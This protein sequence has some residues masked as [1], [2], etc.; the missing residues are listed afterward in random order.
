MLVFRCP[1]VIFINDINTLLPY[2][3]LTWLCPSTPS[4]PK[5]LASASVLFIGSFVI[6]ITM[7][8]P[9]SYVRCS[10]LCSLNRMYTLL[11]TMNSPG[12]CLFVPHRRPILCSPASCVGRLAWSIMSVIYI[13]VLCLYINCG[14]YRK[15]NAYLQDTSRDHY[16]VIVCDLWL[17]S[18]Q[19][20]R[21]SVQCD[22]MVLH[23]KVER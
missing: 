19:E 11:P 9:Y 4:M 2:I 5:Q 10:M 18:L 17:A 22:L 12:F 1:C 6:N 8:H 15:P 23:V 14:Q 13:I 21:L 7:W 3:D 16:F 20:T